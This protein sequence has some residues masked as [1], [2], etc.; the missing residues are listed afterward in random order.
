MCIRDSLTAV[1]KQGTVTLTLNIGQGA[2]GQT[3]YVVP[4]DGTPAVI[5]VPSKIGYLFTGWALP[6]KPNKVIKKGVIPNTDATLVAVWS[7]IPVAKTVYFAAGSS[8]LNSKA[9]TLIANLSK[10]ILAASG[11]QKIVLWGWVQKTK[12][13]KKDAALSLARALAVKK[14]MVN[15]GVNAKYE[16][17]SKGVADASAKGRRADI[18]ILWDSIPAQ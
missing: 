4:V 15:N 18:A 11:I 8:S 7:K 9:L 10:K 2:A 13:T 16:T 6:N 3:S 14:A 12:S 17:T 1:W 5:P